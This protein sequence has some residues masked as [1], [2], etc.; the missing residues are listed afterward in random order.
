MSYV[1]IKSEP[2]L[3]TV[4]IY[5]PDGRWGPES[6][7]DNEASA[8]ERVR[9]LNGGGV[10]P[11]TG[12]ERGQLIAENDELRSMLAHCYAG[13]ALYDED[14]ELQDNRAEPF[15]DFKRDSTAAIRAAMHTRAL[16][17]RATGSES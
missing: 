4:G 11:L 17:S 5:L 13:S 12:D 8:A 3:W 15:I 1:Y 14:G 9:W 16:R 6:D 7:H 10:K 2:Q